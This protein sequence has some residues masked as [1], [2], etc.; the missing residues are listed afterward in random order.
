MMIYRTLA[1][2]AYLDLS[3]EPDIDRSALSSPS[4]T[5]WKATTGATEWP[6]R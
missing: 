4:P 3:I 5:R 6:A 1:D 2:P